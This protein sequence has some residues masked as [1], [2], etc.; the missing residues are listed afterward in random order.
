MLFSKMLHMITIETIDMS[1]DLYYGGEPVAVE[2]PQSLT[3]PYC[4][5]MG[6]TETALQEHVTTDHSETSF[7]VVFTF[8]LNQLNHNAFLV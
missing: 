7:E 3:C 1:V 2:Q 8:S 5:K 4:G 6:F